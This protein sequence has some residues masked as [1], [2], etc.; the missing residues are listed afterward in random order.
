MLPLDT[1]SFHNASSIF[2]HVN[3]FQIGV[4]Q[5]CVRC[6]KEWWNFIDSVLVLTQIIF[7]TISYFSIER[8]ITILKHISILV[9]IE[10]N[11]L[12]FLLKVFIL[13]LGVTLENF[14]HSLK[15]RNSLNIMNDEANS[16]FDLRY[17][18]I[19]FLF[20]ETDKEK[21]IKIFFHYLMW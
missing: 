7:I 1:N 19:Y 6:S 4:L 3:I 10:D 21:W 18:Q 14:G 5:S 16:F 9:Y 8:F 11:V 15:Y 13:S 20:K 17:L 12:H 2:L